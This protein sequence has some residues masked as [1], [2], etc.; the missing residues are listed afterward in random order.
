MA[1]EPLI[2]LVD[3]QGWYIEDA[4]KRE[5]PMDSCQDAERFLHLIQ[6]TNAARSECACLDRECL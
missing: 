6:L 1:K 5:G 3:G 4:G 2:Y